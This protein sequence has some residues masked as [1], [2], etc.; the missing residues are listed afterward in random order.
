MNTYDARRV[1]L[2]RYMR[3]EDAGAWPALT[4]AAWP[5]DAPTVAAWGANLTGSAAF[6]AE[7][8]DIYR[9]GPRRS[10]ERARS[11]AARSH[12]HGLCV[13]RLLG[14]PRSVEPLLK[15]R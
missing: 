1:A 4:N 5:F 11:L 8:W 12:L 6:G 13:R 2:A 9:P 14:L 10:P 7:A 3:E 15:K